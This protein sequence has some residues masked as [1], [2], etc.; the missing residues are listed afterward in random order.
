MKKYRHKQT[1]W[2]AIKRCDNE[3]NVYT[4]AENFLF[5]TAKELIE[6][7]ND[8]EE[9]KPE[10]QEEVIEGWACQLKDNTNIFF[11]EEPL[12]TAGD[13]N[14]YYYNTPATLI[15]NPKKRKEYVR[16]VT[17]DDLRLITGYS[18]YENIF[19]CK[20]K[21]NDRVH[22]ITITVEEEK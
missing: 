9:I 20:H 5:Q 3:Y 18:Q 19:I 21:E 22:K 6:N 12:L 2:I 8:W 13:F 1:G 10:Q 15:L 17:E 11:D 4:K 7:T 14:Y 16:W